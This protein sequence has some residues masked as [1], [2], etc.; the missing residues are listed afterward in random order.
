MQMQQ[1]ATLTAPARIAVTNGQLEHRMLV[2]TARLKVPGLLETM[3]D[4]A[5]EVRR[6]MAKIEADLG[7]S[8]AALDGGGWSVN[9]H[10]V[11]LYNGLVI[12]SFLLSR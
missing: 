6:V 1:E 8:I 4:Q 12:A 2:L 10:S 3:T 9:S 11:A 7:P 5:P